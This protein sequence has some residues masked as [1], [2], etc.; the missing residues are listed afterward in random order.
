MRWARQVLAVLSVLALSLPA[1]GLPADA[2]ASPL[3]T[4]RVSGLA[5]KPSKAGAR[6]LLVTWTPSRS[7]VGYRVQ[8]SMMPGMANA[9]SVVVT[10]NGAL[11]TGLLPKTRYYVRVQTL[12]LSGA[13][14]SGFTP[15]VS[16]RTAKPADAGASPLRVAS[17]N[18]RSV[19]KQG[20]GKPWKVRRRLLANAINAQKLD[21][22]GLQEAEHW[23]VA[24]GVTQY[25]D[26]ANLL[27]GDWRA[28]ATADSAGTRIVY[29]ADK[30]KLVQAGRRQLTSDNKPKR[31]VVW[32]VFEQRSTG[33]K[34]LFANTHLIAGPVVS[35][36]T[37]CS[38]KHPKRYSLRR[39]EAA[40]VVS[41]I[42][43]KAGSLPVVLVG[44]MNAHKFHCPNNG[45]YREFTSAGLVDPLGNTDRHKGTGRSSVPIRIRTE[46]DTS[47]HYASAP[48]RHPWPLGT[49]IDYIWLSRSISSLE[50]EIVVNINASGRFVGPPPSDHNMVRAS[51]LIPG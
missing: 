25:Q 9:H 31:Y 26:I 15:G 49:H 40:Q 3:P 17:Y 43:A 36:A 34:F 42:R 30:V 6:T 37:S 24:G 14:L 2:S 18:V 5:V 50:Y 39:K 19:R 27:T 23:K 4:G 51:I 45:P 44:D 32:S 46:Y 16:A 33:R 47:N 12:S 7:L 22:L 8:Y 20:K 1:S 28:V 21:V 10:G 13:S 38:G 48:K 41:T 11:L 35:S 29:N